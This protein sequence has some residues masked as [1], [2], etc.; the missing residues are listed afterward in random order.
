MATVGETKRSPFSTLHHVTIVVRDVDKAVEFY[1]SLGIG[2]FVDYPPL[3]EYVRLNV[4][5]L[6]GFH[7][8]WHR[9]P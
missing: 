4:P 2:P 9:L 1:E 7:R 3:S 6:I 8:P 5:D